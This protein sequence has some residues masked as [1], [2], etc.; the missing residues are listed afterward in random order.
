MTYA[1]ELLIPL[2]HGNCQCLLSGCLHGGQMSGT[3]REIKTVN[4]IKLSSL[5]MNNSSKGFPHEDFHRHYFMISIYLM[6][7]V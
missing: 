7:E 2:Y 1:A 5:D 6:L 3:E 4:W